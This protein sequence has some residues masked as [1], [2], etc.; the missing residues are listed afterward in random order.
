MP[1]FM[2]LDLVSDKSVFFEEEDEFLAQIKVVEAM[3]EDFEKY[4]DIRLEFT[5]ESE[6]RANECNGFV[7]QIISS[8]HTMMSG[9]MK[10]THVICRIEID[11]MQFESQLKNK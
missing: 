6:R 2:L 3:A 1:K 7:Y 5:K 9:A 8:V 10:A 11:G 4:K